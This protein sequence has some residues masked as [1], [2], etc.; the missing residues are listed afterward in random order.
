MTVPGPSVPGAAIPGALT[1]GYPEAPAAASYQYT[2]HAAAYYLQYLGPGGTLYATPGAGFSAGAISVASGWPY[3]LAVPPADGNW[4]ST[5]GFTLEV[6]FR[7]PALSEGHAEALARGRARN[8][9]A[10]ARN[11]ASAVF[12]HGRLMPVREP[13]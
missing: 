9:R 1:P 2:G 7:R 12:L 3:L 8:S 6:V 11:A 10:Q 5:D 13:S 4:T